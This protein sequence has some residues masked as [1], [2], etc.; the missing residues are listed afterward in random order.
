MKRRL[1]AGDVTNFGCGGAGRGASFRGVAFALTLI[2]LS[3]LA[4]HATAQN[5]EPAPPPPPVYAVPPAPAT[6]FAGNAPGPT[7]EPCESCSHWPVWLA[8]GTAVVAAAVIG[9][10]YFRQDKDLSMPIT[11][12][13]SKRFQG[14]R[15]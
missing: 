4:G 3:G 7:A 13:G 10:M 15:P 14:A 1:R 5:W 12:Y 2:S 9:I 6:T 11:S 8:V